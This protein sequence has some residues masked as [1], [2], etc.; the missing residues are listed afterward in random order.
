MISAET[1]TILRP[2]S[3]TQYKTYNLRLWLR[4]IPDVT[5]SALHQQYYEVSEQSAWIAR[6]SIAK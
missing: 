4:L 5:L 1:A 6:S 2:M 3:Y